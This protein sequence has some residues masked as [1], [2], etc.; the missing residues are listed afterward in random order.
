MGVSARSGS[1]YEKY[2][3]GKGEVSPSGSTANLAASVF[4]RVDLPD[5]F[6]SL[7]CA[8]LA[9]RS[10]ATCIKTSTRQ[11]LKMSFRAIFYGTFGAAKKGAPESPLVR[12]DADILF[13]LDEFCNAANVV[14]V[15][16]I[17]CGMTDFY[18]IAIRSSE[19]V[20]DVKHYGVIDRNA[21]KR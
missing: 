15:C 18:Q 13:C 6:A 20:L 21:C 14:F 5:G 8:C 10:E 19:N 3:E 12:Y 9:E 4:H 11:D 7:A 2:T 17:I 16:L 1:F